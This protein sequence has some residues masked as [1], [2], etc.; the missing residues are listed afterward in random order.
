MVAR[1]LDGTRVQ[2]VQ[3]VTVLGPPPE[4]R[5][6]RAPSRATVGEPYRLSFT[7]AHTVGAQAQVSTDEGVILER[8]Y[9]KGSREGELVWT[10]TAAG[11]AEVTIHA[12]GTSE[13]S[14]T[15]RV[16]V[17]VGVRDKVTTPT[18]EF[19]RVPDSVVVGRPV[20]F[21]VTASGCS[22]GA[23]Q[24]RAPDGTTSSWSFPCPAGRAVIS[25]T[26]HAPGPHTLTATARSGAITVQ[27]KIR[28][29]VRA[30]RDGAGERD[31][32]R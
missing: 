8:R 14:V 13:R 24:V 23:A 29:V 32:A 26:P 17:E 6:I 19:L 4:L 27:T 2:A 30:P 25:W 1:G 31:P 15:R 22:A 3:S 9:D 28:V 5:I 18:V 16:G 20:R 10:P 7:L 11:V 21:S 12:F